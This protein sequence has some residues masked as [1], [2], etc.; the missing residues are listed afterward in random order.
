MDLGLASKAEEKESQALE[1]PSPLSEID[2]EA[3]N[4]EKALN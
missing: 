4:V 2:E 3:K 1:V